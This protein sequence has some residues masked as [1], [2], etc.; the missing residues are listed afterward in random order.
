MVLNEVLFNSE[1]RK[2]KGSEIVIH[3][4]DTPYY[5]SFVLK[6]HIYLQNTR[7]ILIDDLRFILKSLSE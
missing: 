4:D 1:I 3:M 5:M 2:L 6:G 7:K